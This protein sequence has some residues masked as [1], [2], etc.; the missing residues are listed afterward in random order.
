MKQYLI[1]DTIPNRLNKHIMAPRRDHHN[2]VRNVLPPNF[3]RIAMT[4][5]GRRIN[6]QVM[7]VRKKTEHL[8]KLPLRS[9]SQ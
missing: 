3:G 5:H 8:F 2:R 7:D 6:H 9:L 1:P 4:L